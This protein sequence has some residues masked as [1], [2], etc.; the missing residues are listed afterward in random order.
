MIKKKKNEIDYKIFTNEILGY[1]KNIIKKIFDKLDSKK[2]GFIIVK[3]IRDN[4]NAK[5]KFFS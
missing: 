1:R 5:R 2:E 3:D 4:Y